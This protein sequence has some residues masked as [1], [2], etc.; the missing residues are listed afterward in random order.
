MR[1][2]TP[3]NRGH[4]GAA[5]RL[6]LPPARPQSPASLRA[7]GLVLWPPGHAPAPEFAGGQRHVLSAARRPEPTPAHWHLRIHG[8]PLPRLSSVPSVHTSPGAH[9]PGPRGCP[10]PPGHLRQPPEG[11]F[12][13][14]PLQSRPYPVRRQILYRPPPPPR[15]S[16]GLWE[17]IPTSSAWPA[18]QPAGP[19]PPPSDHDSSAFRH[20]E[21]ALARL[22]GAPAPSL[23]TA[24]PQRL[25]QVSPA[26][27]GSV[28][29][30]PPPRTPP[31]PPRHPLQHPDLHPACA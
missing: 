10:L 9:C 3:T 22:L 29:T 25:A 1:T 20:T 7:L 12:H 26:P 27:S 23:L 21:R 28:P 5:D 24:G 11:L 30:L 31:R 8:C 13:L 4:M 14:L 18:R 2:V 19:R 16:S 17:Q 6:H 15:S